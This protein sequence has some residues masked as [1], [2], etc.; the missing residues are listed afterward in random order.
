MW[1]EYNGREPEKDRL[2]GDGAPTRKEG[3]DGLEASLQIVQPH[4]IGRGFGDISTEK[5]GKIPEKHSWRMSADFCG[6]WTHF[7]LET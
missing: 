2:L 6:S 7:K 3:G 4:F 5:S 1:S